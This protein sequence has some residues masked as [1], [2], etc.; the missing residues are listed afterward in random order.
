[1]AFGQD[2]API[3]APA[4]PKPSDTSDDIDR[5]EEG[6]YCRKLV[7]NIYG[8]FFSFKGNRR[9]KRIFK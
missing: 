6:S 5:F 3:T 8:L 2:C 9:K 7:S 4:K 1:M